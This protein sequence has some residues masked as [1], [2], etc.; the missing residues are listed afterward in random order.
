MVS[1]QFLVVTM[2]ISGLLYN[3]Y[4]INFKKGFGR[5]MYTDYEIVCK[6]CLVYIF[7]AREIILLISPL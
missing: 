5:K 6:V 7:C 2:R 3:S 4:Y 1:L